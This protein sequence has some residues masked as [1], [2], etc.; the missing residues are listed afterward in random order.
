MPSVPASNFGFPIGETQRI[1]F[2]MLAEYTSIT[3]GR[4]PAEEIREF[5]AKNG[6]DALNFKANLSWTGSTLNRGLFPTRGRSQTLALELAVPGSDL[7][8]YKLTYNGQIYF[9]LT[10]SLT[11]RLRTELG[12]GDGYGSTVG[13]PFYEH[14]FSGGFG[15][16]RGFERST[17]GPRSTN[18][19]Q[20]RDGNPIPPGFFREDGEPF[21]GNMLVEASAEVIFPLPFVDDSR[22]FRPVLFVD[23]GNVFNTNCPDVST[24]CFDF[25]VD[26]LRYS[27]GVGMT[28]LTGLGPMTFAIAKPFNTQEFDEEERFQFELGQ[29]F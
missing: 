24:S 1:N 14:F 20:D 7:Q 4:F 10:R 3:E 19:T 15:S 23:V 8:F 27:V 5:L 28:W 11:L 17:L 16:I 22:Q 18:P 25:D 13:L 12:Y 9:P 21:G 6:D 29:T 26:E 2:G